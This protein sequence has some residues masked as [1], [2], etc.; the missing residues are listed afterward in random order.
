MAEYVEEFV[1]SVSMKL[2]VIF[3]Q[4]QY[5]IGISA[6]N[7]TK[8]KKDQRDSGENLQKIKSI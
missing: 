3:L 7:G 6:V 4:I 5:T 8:E 1:L 2:I